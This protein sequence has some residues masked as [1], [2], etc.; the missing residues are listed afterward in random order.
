M[1]FDVQP[2]THFL[3][4]DY[5]IKLQDSQLTA[6]CF[7]SCRFPHGVTIVL[8]LFKK[9]IKYEFKILSTLHVR[10]ETLGSFSTA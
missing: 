10:A 7:D 1:G 8:L 2:V 9:K 5:R 6:R 4:K 3:K